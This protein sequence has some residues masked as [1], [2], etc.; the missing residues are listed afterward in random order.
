MPGLPRGA[1]VTHFS[2]ARRGRMWLPA[3]AHCRAYDHTPPPFGSWGPQ[4]PGG[5]KLLS[6]PSCSDRPDFQ[7][8]RVCSAPLTVSRLARAPARF[9]FRLC[10]APAPPAPSW[11]HPYE[12]P[13][14]CLRPL[15]FLPER[16][17]RGRG[18]YRRLTHTLTFTGTP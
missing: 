16:P 4:I 17:C 1:G 13:P 15:P 10:P 18:A 14:P 7:G 12:A 9:P 11:L 5:W 6:P 2:Y 8:N 3:P